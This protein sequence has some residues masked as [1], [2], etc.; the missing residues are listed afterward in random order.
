MARRNF[1]GG[2][3]GVAGNRMGGAGGERFQGHG[4][5]VAQVNVKKGGA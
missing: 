3:D 4:D 2:G 5:V 1:A